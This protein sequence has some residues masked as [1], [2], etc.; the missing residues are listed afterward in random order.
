MG[1]VYKVLDTEA[2]REDRPQAHPARDRPRTRTTI[3]RFS[4]RAQ[5]GPPGRPQERLPGCSTSART[6]GV[7]YITMEYVHGEDLKRLIRKVGQLSR[8]PGRRRSPARS[9]TGLAEAHRLGIVHRDLKP[10]NIMIDEEGQAKILDFGLARLLD[11]ERID[12][13]QGPRSGTP[14]YISP[15]ADQGRR[16]ADARSDIYSLGVLIYEMLTGAHAVQGRRAS[17]SIAGH[18]PPRQIPRRRASSTRGISA[19]LST[20]VMKRL[21]KDPAAAVSSRRR[22]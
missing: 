18:A 20:L 5:A 3:E 10:Q 19:E 17:K 4:Q 15:G 21:A 7:P 22:S 6:D 16:P 8:R 2:Q 9:A 1:R 14:A 11:P 12:G 13:R